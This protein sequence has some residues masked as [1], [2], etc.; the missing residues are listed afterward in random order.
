MKKMPNPYTFA[1]SYKIKFILQMHYMQTRTICLQVSSTDN[2]IRIP[3]GGG[4]KC[5]HQRPSELDSLLGIGPRILHFQH[6]FP[7]NSVLALQT[8][9]LDKSLAIPSEP[10]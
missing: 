3:R 7:Q 9:L 2:Y 8:Q 5:C 4:E 1:P 6:L 10:I